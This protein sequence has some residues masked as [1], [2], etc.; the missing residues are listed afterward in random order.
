M[1]TAHDATDADPFQLARFVAA[2]DGIY[3]QV[4]QEIRTGRKRSHWMWFIFPQLEGLGTSEMARRYAIS[5]L[6]E[7]QAYLTHPLLG[8][9]LIEC[10][11]IVNGL[12]GSSALQIFGHPDDRKLR[13]SLTLFE[14]VAGNRSDFSSALDKY[15]AGQRDPATLQRLQLP[16]HGNDRS[17]T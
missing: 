8:T 5:G 2:Q 10:T 4:V 7:A 17:G 13:S 3:P 16:G 9:R 11:R 1:S 12:P 15:F 6:P 14:L